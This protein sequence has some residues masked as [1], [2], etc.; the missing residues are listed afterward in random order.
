MLV[1]ILQFPFK[2]GSIDLIN[3]W[4]ILNNYAANI[5]YGWE[6]SW[7]CLQMPYGISE[8]SNQSIGHDWGDESVSQSFRQL[9]I[10]GPCINSV[11]LEWSLVRCVRVKG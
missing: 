5:G 9:T 2:M 4:A 6:R 7:G 3:K 11:L 1:L 10:C 8:G